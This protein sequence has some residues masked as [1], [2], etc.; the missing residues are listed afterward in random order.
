MEARNTGSIRRGKLGVQEGEGIGSSLVLGAGWPSA[1]RCLQLCGLER[2]QPDPAPLNRQ[3]RAR[4]NG[5]RSPLA[6]WGRGAR[7]AREENAGL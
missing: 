4:G 6:V 7:E 3:V 2:A 5:R 1:G